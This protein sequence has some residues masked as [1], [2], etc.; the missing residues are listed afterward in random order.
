MSKPSKYRLVALDLDGTL[1]TSD[2]AILPETAAVLKQVRAR[3][4]DVVLVTGRHHIMAHPYHAEL[5]LDTPVVC[6]NG[7]YL[8]DF[9]S[10]Q[11]LASNP[12][13]H[14]RALALLE[15]G[16]RINVDLVLY[17]DQ[18]M[19]CTR[20]DKRMSALD[21]WRQT[22][23]AALRPDIRITSNGFEQDIANA[24]SVWKMVVSHDDP[25]QINDFVTEVSSKM[26]I[27]C[28]WSWA[29]RVDITSEGNSKGNR[30]AELLAQRK[31]DLSEVIAFGDHLNDL[32]MLSIVGMGIAMG[33]AEQEVRNGADMVTA[34]NDD[35]GIA[36]ALRKLVLEN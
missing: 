18:S 25:Q 20:Y 2:Q 26:P 31:I 33:N 34:A 17:I 16:K 23:P 3:G 12:L 15:C 35:N 22:V 27:S 36:K 24:Q 11:V 9:A 13:G 28:E 32:S 14:E 29:N 30:L 10:N 5:G 7:T 21:A 8:Y 6:C 1:L 19:I 4:I